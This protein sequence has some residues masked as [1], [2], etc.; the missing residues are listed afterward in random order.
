MGV[1]ATPLSSYLSEEFNQGC[2]DEETMGE[3]PEERLH[4]TLF[5]YLYTFAKAQ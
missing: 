1:I 4:H 5:R 2:E 3:V